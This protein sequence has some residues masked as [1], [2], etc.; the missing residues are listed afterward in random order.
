MRHGITSNLESI[1]RCELARGTVSIRAAECS[2]PMT[3]KRASRRVLAYISHTR[4]PYE[5]RVANFYFS[6]K[7]GPVE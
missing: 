3:C 5:R 2:S 7:T 1:Y 6:V 4:V